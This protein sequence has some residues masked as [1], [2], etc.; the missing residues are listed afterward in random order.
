MD[1]CDAEPVTIRLYAAG[2][3]N[4][5]LEE[6]ILEKVRRLQQ[7]KQEEV[8]RFAGGLQ[9][10]ALSEVVGGQVDETP[11]PWL[12]H[13]RRPR[14]EISNGDKPS[15]WISKR[16]RQRRCILCTGQMSATA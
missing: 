12:W 1:I 3:D 2:R 8:L 9:R 14:P 11:I 15:K 4:H 10:Q 16:Y 5:N 7:D 13:R 6:A